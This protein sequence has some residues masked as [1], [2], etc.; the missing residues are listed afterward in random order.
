MAGVKEF[1]TE[2]EKQKK[3][4]ELER[5]KSANAEAFESVVDVDN[6]TM[7]APVATPQQLDQMLADPAT[8]NVDV[9]APV[10]ATIDSATAPVV[11][12]PA[13]L[14]P[15]QISQLLAGPETVNVDN[16][17]VDTIAQP[18]VSAAAPT[19]Q[20]PAQVGLTPE[21]RARI[22]TR[23][24]RTN[25][26]IVASG[27]TVP[28]L[29]A[30]TPEAFNPVGG[31]FSF[32]GDTPIPADRESG[33]I[34]EK[35]EFLT[36]GTPVF[37]NQGQA[38]APTSEVA[39]AVE[40]ATPEP[41]ANLSV[42]G[43]DV[44]TPEA[45]AEAGQAAPEAVAPQ[46]PDNLDP[47]RFGRGM[48]QRNDTGRAIIDGVE[49]TPEQVAL[50]N[51][52]ERERAKAGYELERKRI[53][54]SRKE[55]ELNPPPAPSA[56]TPSAP[57]RETIKERDYREK[58]RSDYL[59]KE[60]QKSI[61]DQMRDFNRQPRTL[62]ER[63]VEK[64][65]LENELKAS[66][67][68]DRNYNRSLMSADYTNSMNQF[69]RNNLSATQRADVNYRNKPEKSSENDKAIE[70]IKQNLPQEQQNDAI[71]NILGVDPFDLPEVRKTP[72]VPSAT[73]T[74]VPGESN[75]IA[76]EPIVLGNSVVPKG[77]TRTQEDEFGEERTW[78]FDG[79]NWNLV[80]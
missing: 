67:K 78:K 50:F 29:G 30:A 8:V 70:W 69:N 26:D 14:T 28:S 19:A 52:T 2:V 68:E 77:H 44:V 72:L 10:G 62:Q 6:P 36:G 15:Q 80:K 61:R 17:P 54:K 73:A 32:G 5:N 35:E 57:T 16:A 59:A 24:A 23:L 76:S 41:V 63:K 65:R 74:A 3:R 34:P 79:K 49:A 20:A 60:G 53:E 27:E 39:P 22:K 66:I 71:L 12:A 1:L 31:G 45:I 51:S 13:F 38:P 46:S 42:N 37:S 21:E 11:Q 48:V 18:D 7:Q 33:F 55:R 40:M 75:P 4:D 43:T 9:A 64:S 25:A 56:P 58:K 47:W